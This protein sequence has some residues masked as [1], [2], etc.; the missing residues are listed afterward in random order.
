MANTLSAANSV[1]VTDAATFIPELWSDEIV[2]AYKSNLVLANLVTRMNH[3]GK[4]GDT[5]HIPSPLRKTASAK[6][7]NNAVTLITDTESQ[8]NVLI[9]RH[10]E[11]SRL[12]EDIVEV[13]A[14]SSLRR[15]Y[16]DDAGYALAKST[17]W[18]LHVLGTGLQGG[19][20]DTSSIDPPGT[21]LT[22]GSGTV[23]GSDGTTA[24]SPTT[25]GNGATLSDAGIRKMMQT[26]D[27]ADVPMTERYLVIPP[28]EKKS[29]L[30]LSRFTE[31][32]FVGEVGGANSIRNG[33]VG[34][35]YGA[36]VFVSTNC[37][38]TVDA[39]ATNSFR[40]GLLIHKSAFVLVEQLGVRSQTQYKQEFLA[41]LLT[42]D[43]IYGVA[44]LRDTAGVAYICPA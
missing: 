3:R 10:F 13:Q 30:G 6:A 24:W 19:T 21:V 23:I 2:A 7:A 5:V 36:S 34:D 26:L 11:Y 20:P 14:L 4:K 40:A 17:D 1:D 27:D 9:D 37:G 12:I 35:I 44:E 32:A 29:L 41:D 43:T 39:G 38:F 16:T 18:H 31:Q 28:V 33:M 22:Y 42:A 8:V 15:F 25:N